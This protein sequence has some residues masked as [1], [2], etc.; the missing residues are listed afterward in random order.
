MI[1]FD[2]E[3]R[4]L[5]QGRDAQPPLGH[6]PLRRVEHGPGRGDPRRPRHRAGGQADLQYRRLLRRPARPPA[7]S[8]PARA[9]SI[10][11]ACSKGVVAGVRDYG[12]RMGIP[13][14]NGALVR[15]PGLPGQSAG[16]L[17]DRRRASRGARRSRRSSRATGSSSIGGRTGR[18]GIHGATFSSAEL[19]GES[20]SISGGAVQIGNAITE[21]MVLDVIAPGPRPGPLPRH[22]RLRRRGV[23]LG[24]RRD[25]GRARGRRRPRPGPAQVPGPLLHRDLDLR[26]PGADGPG[27]PAGALA[28]PARALCSASTSRPPTWASSSPPAGSPCATTA[29]SSPTC[30]WTSST[31]AGRRSSGRA[32]LHAPARTSRSSCPSRA[33]FTGDLIA[34]LG[35]WDVCSKEWIVRQYDHE[36][37]GRTVI[38][39]LVG[40]RDDGPG[41][42]SVILPVRGS[43]R[44]L[45]IS[46]GINPRYGRLDPYAMAA[47]V[48][49]E[50]I[51]NCVAVG[52]DPAADRPARQLLLGQHRTPRDPRRRWSSPR[53][54]ATTSPWPTGRR[55]SRAR[56]ASTT[57]TPT[58]ARAWPSPPRS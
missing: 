36:V 41:D 58:T 1:R 57:S 42:A 50:A 7:R 40:D 32:T 45:A 33:D 8:A 6:R 44:G 4:R 5:L 24:R 52:A 9:C 2:D 46:C 13:T 31:R 30:R 34:L 17:R 23:Q 51:R 55:S 22:H 39:P 3:L 10:P 25:G 43:N 19:T 12:N 15:R 28:G 27:R 20:E 16:L 54:R 11:G 38:K 21:K 53:R 26:G 47:C 56:T 29:R 48:I 18:D 35:H 49:D 14:V 37:Q